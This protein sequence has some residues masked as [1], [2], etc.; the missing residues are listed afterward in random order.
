MIDAKWLLAAII[1]SGAGMI[2]QDKK[3]YLEQY[4]A[5]FA[6]ILLFDD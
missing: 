2:A 4:L 3:N 1:N 6:T 5:M